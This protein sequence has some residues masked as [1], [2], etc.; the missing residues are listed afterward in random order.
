MP[1]REYVIRHIYG[2]WRLARL[3]PS[4]MGC[5]DVSIGGFW[6]S[7]FAAVVVAPFYA[8]L[9]IP[10]VAHEIAAGVD[11]SLFIGVEL[12]VYAVGWAAFPIVMVLLAR[13]LSLEAAYVPYI[14]AYNWSAVV[15][16]GVFLPVTLLS[17]SAVLSEGVSGLLVMIA[18][19]AIWAYQWFIARV[20]LGTTAFTAA[21]LVILDQLLG[22]LIARSAD[23]II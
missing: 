8:A 5:F 1:S 22:Y 7:F 15:Q 20:A 23:A 21:G 12:M 18:V 10:R 14:I 11:V 3:D 2:V 17:E 6:R 13:L 9:V 4:G 16:V 19:L